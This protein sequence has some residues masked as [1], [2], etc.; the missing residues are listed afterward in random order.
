MNDNEISDFE[1]A[2]EQILAGIRR[3][4]SDVEPS[5]PRPRAYDADAVAASGLGRGRVRSRIGFA[6]L[7]PLVLVAALVVIAVGFGM[8][9][10][11][12]GPAAPSG[13]THAPAGIVTITYQLEGGALSAS[14]LDNT[15]AV[16]SRR[17]SQ[18][19]P[20]MASSDA[21]G[22]LLPDS[23]RSTGFQV[24]PEPPDRVAISFQADYRVVS[25]STDLWDLDSIRAAMGQPGHVE[26]VG[27]PPSV[28]GSGGVAGI[29]GLPQRGDPID[30]ALPSVLTGADFDASRI[31]EG[32]AS[33]GGG[34]LDIALTASSAQTWS[35]HVASNNGHYVALTLDGK[36]IETS[37]LS[38]RT[39]VG[40]LIL[41]TGLAQ[42][43]ASVLIWFLKSG[44]LPVPLAEVSFSSSS[45]VPVPSGP[46]ATPTPILP[47]SASQSASGSN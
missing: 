43:D 2:D 19:F 39:P 28:Y 16:L 33:D 44:A 29:K 37:L 27:L 15:V 6:G 40:H 31:A 22:S 45:Q 4:L 17:L 46:E 41:T 18:I 10:R 14:D 38:S 8:S 21:A 25:G 11:S 3:H 1:P 24:T 13:N 12:S 26:I 47:P 7:A 32:T 35:D 9:L 20:Q 36:V 42:R 23:S 30:P 34:P 5:L